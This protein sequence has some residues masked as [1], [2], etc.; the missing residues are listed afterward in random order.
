MSAIIAIF[1]LTVIY[2]IIETIIQSHHPH[3]ESKTNH[4]FSDRHTCFLIL[5]A[6]MLAIYL[7]SAL[8]LFTAQDPAFAIDLLV[9]FLFS[10]FIIR[11]IEEWMYKKAEKEYIHSFIGASYFLTAFLILSFLNFV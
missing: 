3:S 6:C 9:L 11:G 7:L 4:P 10:I 5:E 8:F 1:M 2:L